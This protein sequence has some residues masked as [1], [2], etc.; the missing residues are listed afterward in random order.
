MQVGAR[1]AAWNGAARRGRCA[2]IM[3]RD[4]ERQETLAV[5]LVGK[6]AGGGD[7]MGSILSQLLG[8]GS[9]RAGNEPAFG[10]CT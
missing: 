1:E 5:T 2:F 3:K 8:L 6:S 4:R 10:D 7:G 9:V